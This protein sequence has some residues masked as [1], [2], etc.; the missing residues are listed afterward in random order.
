MTKPP[1]WRSVLYVPTHVEKFVA[2]AHTRGADALILDLEDSVP[3]DEKARARGLIAAA[4]ATVGQAG[5]DVL[6]RINAEAALAAED[7]AAADGPRVVALS[8]P[9]VE[10]PAQVRDLDDAVSK[11]EARAGVETGATRFILIIESAAA[12]LNMGALAVA[13]P[14]TVAISLGAED[15]ALDVGM[16][17]T[18]ET[19]LFPKQQVVIHAAAAG[20][21][22]LGLVGGATRFDDPDAYL[23]LAERSRRFGYV[24]ATCVHPKQ[25]PLLNVAF[26]PGEAEVAHARRVL[27]G[28][29]A[30]AAEGR[31]AFAIDGRMVDP[32]IVARAETL[33]ARHEAIRARTKRSAATAE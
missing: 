2:A 16:E 9:K 6:V 20:V 7:I 25:V 26:A 18:D 28:A 33:L 8:L 4:A 31:G 24:G 32:P 22:P 3:W 30:A 19:L 23:A 11:A 10:T 12:Y 5:A 17:P 27:E 14:R 1:V 15:F 13:S 29:Q 21:M